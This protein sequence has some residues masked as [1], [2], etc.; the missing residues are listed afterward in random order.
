VTAWTP[1]CIPADD[2]HRAVFFARV[3]GYFRGVHRDIEWVR[4]LVGSEREQAKCGPH[5]RAPAQ[6]ESTEDDDAAC[7][8]FIGTVLADAW[9]CSPRV[10]RKACVVRVADRVRLGG[11]PMTPHT[12][13]SPCT[14]PTS[15]IEGS[16]R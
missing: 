6:E 2:R 3:P 12:A 11:E 5:L 10:G 14:V 7:R 8:L 4:V 13:N 1:L 15:L 16:S 9:R